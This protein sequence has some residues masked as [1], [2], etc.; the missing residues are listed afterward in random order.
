MSITVKHTFVS[1]IADDPNDAAAGKVVPSNWNAAHTITGQV[2]LATDVT[3]NLPVTNL[4]SGT[5]AST[6]TF[7][8]GDG[9]WAAAGGGNPGGSATQLQFFG[10]SGSFAGVSGSAVDGNG[11]LTLG[12]ATVTTSD[13]VLNMTQTWNASTVSFVFIKANA[14]DTQSASGSLIYD[15]QVG[16]STRSNVN[17]AGISSF[18]S[19]DGSG[20]VLHLTSLYQGVQSI[21]LSSGFAF[22]SNVY[23]SSSAY[24]GWSGGPE[25]W[26]NTGSQVVLF[27]DGSG[28]PTVNGWFNYAGQTRV[29]SDFNASTSSLINV[30][31]LSVPLAAGRSYQFE[32][33]LF[34]TDAAAGGVQAAINGSVLTATNI[35]YEGYTL[36]S[37]TVKGQTQ[38]TALGTAVASTTTTGTT[39]S[40]RIQGLITVNVAGNINVQVA[41]NTNNATATVVKRGSY[42][43][44]QDLQ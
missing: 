42:L 38:A 11:S 29:T 13:P 21:G 43:M 34:C 5:G 14:T 17:K 16:G 39:P 3:G 32:A 10:S 36:D 23:V 31:G 26:K 40:V 12:G 24:I 19:V 25:L 8:R 15:F 2:S 44:V 7:W 18:T 4:N 35:I 33:V 27:G 9:T 28:S 6:S 41:Q 22:S 20:D 37:N 1:G 30:T